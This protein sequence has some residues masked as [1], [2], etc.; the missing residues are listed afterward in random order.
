VLG[1]PK[2]V[3]ERTLKKAYHKLAPQY[4]PDKNP[5]DKV[6]EDK[7][8]EASEAYEVLSDADKRAHYDRFG[9]N[10]PDLGGGFSAQ[11]YAVNLQDIFGDLFGDIFGGRRRGG[12]NRGGRENGDRAGNGGE[13]AVANDSAGRQN[14]GESYAPT[15]HHDHGQDGGDH[16][17]AAAGGTRAVKPA[18]PTRAKSRAGGGGGFGAAPALSGGSTWKP[19]SAV[20]DSAEVVFVVAPGQSQCDAVQKFCTEHGLDRLVVL[21][22]ARCL[23]EPPPEDADE[24]S[25]QLAR[26]TGTGTAAPKAR[27]YFDT[28]FKDVYAFLTD[29]A[30]KTQDPAVLFKRGVDE[31]W[32]LVSKPKVGPP[33]QLLQSADRP[34]I[35]AMRAAVQAK[36][37]EGLLD[38]L[39]GVFGR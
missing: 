36:Q 1:V 38:A 25:T 20:P 23:E 18:N 30:G 11:Q 12:R 7:F 39:G 34:T 26:A 33:R 22:N 14:D 6:A 21:L 31:P 19:A 37:Q 17:N 2:D 8:K 9:H 10:A 28:E 27:A 16:Q 4:H 24:A 29:P 5:G 13:G 35:A 32:S 15:A 3:D